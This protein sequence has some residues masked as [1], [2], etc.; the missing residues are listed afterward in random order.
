M[1]GIIDC[2]CTG[3][4]AYLLLPNFVCIHYTLFILLVHLSMNEEYI[5][6]YIHILRGLNYKCA[7][8]LDNLT[9]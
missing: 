3:Y 1:Q 6:I 2:L 8:P 7:A 9:P 5:S 4:V